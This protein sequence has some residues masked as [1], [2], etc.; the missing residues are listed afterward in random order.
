MK[1][2]F[3]FL[4]AFVMVCGIYA[5][6]DH[7]HAVLRG[8]TAD[9]EEVAVS[10][11]FDEA[12]YDEVALVSDVID[13]EPEDW[14]LVREGGTSWRYVGGGYCRDSYG[15]SY[16]YVA[17]AKKCNV[18]QCKWQCSQISDFGRL[19]GLSKQWERTGLCI[20]HFDSG[21]LRACPKGATCQWNLKN[22]AA[23]RG[24]GAVTKYVKSSGWMCY[25]D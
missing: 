12:E 22:G 9:Y 3:P 5:Q 15:R 13:E 18:A 20:C 4:I 2:F 24:T 17:Y 21:T 1:A 19:V 23:R 14:A 10:D 6:E 16:P 11:A 25:S 7:P 8:N